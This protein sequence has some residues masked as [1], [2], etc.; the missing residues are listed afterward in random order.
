MPFVSQA[1]R[2]YLFAKHPDVARLYA[3][4]TPPGA[5]LPERARKKRK[6]AMKKESAGW[7]GP[8]LGTTYGPDAQ[9]PSTQQ[10]V[11][12]TP[13]AAPGQPAAGQGTQGL[14]ANAMAAMKP[15]QMPPPQAAAPAAGPGVPSATPSATPLKD[16]MQ[17]I[18]AKL[19]TLKPLT[20]GTLNGPTG[21]GGMA[22]G[23]AKMA[24]APVVGLAALGSGLAGA[25]LGAALAPQGN[26]REGALRGFQRGRLTGTGGLGG[27]LGG[28]ILGG[29]AGT[30]LGV[31]PTAAQMAGGAIGGIGG[32]ALGSKATD[33]VYGPPSW[34]SPRD[35]D[36]DGK[37][38]DGMKNEREAKKEAG[39]GAGIFSRFATS[40]LGDPVRKNVA[41]AVGRA[42]G[43]PAAPQPAPRAMPAPVRPPV[44][45][46]A[47]PSIKLSG[48]KL[49][50]RAGIGQ[51]A[52]N[53]KDTLKSG[54]TA[55]AGANPAAP[56][57]RMDLSNL[58]KIDYPAKNVAYTG[59]AAGGLLAGGLGI[60]SHLNAVNQANQQAKAVAP[61]AAGAASPA[62][63]SIG[64]GA[65]GASLGGLADA[66]TLPGRAADAGALASAGGAGA[67]GSA[68][69]QAL[70]SAPP[71]PKPQPTADAPDWLS[72]NGTNLALGGAAAL[73]GYGLYRAMRGDD[74]EDDREKRSATMLHRELSDDENSQV[75]S[76]SSR[77]LPDIVWGAGTPLPRTMSSPTAGA[78]LHGGVGAAL[79]GAA[80][81]GIGAL[82]GNAGA[83]AAI[84][85]GLGGLGA[86]ARGYLSRSRWNED[87]AD[88]MRRLPEGATY[89]DYQADAGE[90]YEGDKEQNLRAMRYIAKDMAGDGS[91]Q[92]GMFDG[93][94]LADVDPVAPRPKS[95]TNVKQFGGRKVRVQSGAITH[96][97]GRFVGQSK[98][99]AEADMGRRVAELARAYDAC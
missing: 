72:R 18:P 66:A 31:D 12:A 77:V 65:A 40:V 73:G 53:F 28:A 60:K 32:A 61:L 16:Q 23:M 90:G 26:R 71:A 50:T 47:P 84:G 69:G 92:A 3:D 14:F 11:Q 51:A 10:S 63:A 38:R 49:P 95:P 6:P 68:L 1:Q 20:H 2:R 13:P 62:I 22:P 42:M 27:G 25:G 75:E 87:T 39:D 48:I 98:S 59:I 70:A 80:G 91:K 33:W 79:G 44:A 85:A 36:R 54:L 4:H 24:Y 94:D 37:V 34:K 82:A 81:A 83:G 5:K 15:A 41:P 29:M 21:V 8:M 45:A 52:G 64:A 9:L 93:T 97:N 30:A 89:R 88:L 46:A 58:R 56:A 96:E 43:V 86:G 55:R 19:P 35:G 74:E 7:Q 76:N 17:T 99:A 67:A 57:P 78:V